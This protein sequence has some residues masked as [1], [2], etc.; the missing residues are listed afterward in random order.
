MKRIR[1][2][3][4]IVGSIDGAA[5]H[6]VTG[7]HKAWDLAVASIESAGSDCRIYDAQIEHSPVIALFT[8]HEIE[9]DESSPEVTDGV[10]TSWRSEPFHTSDGQTRY[11]LANMTDFGWKWVEGAE[12]E[13]PFR[14]NYFERNAERYPQGWIARTMELWAEIRDLFRP[15][16]S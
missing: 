10:R 12:R 15:V 7:W 4:L 2:F 5:E 3:K 13:L 8:D 16:G 9:E 14:L 11:A 1:E 6:R